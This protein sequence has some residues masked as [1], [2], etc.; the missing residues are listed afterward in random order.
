MVIFKPSLN[1][2]IGSFS[3][4]SPFLYSISISL[5][6]T[7]Y[8]NLLEEK[9]KQ[10]NNVINKQNEEK[11]KLWAWSDMT[12]LD[13]INEKT[14]LN[15]VKKEIAKE[16]VPRKNYVGTLYAQSDD[17]E[18]IL[19][20]SENVFRIKVGEKCGEGEWHEE[21][22]CEILE[23]YKGTAD[24]TKQYRIDLLCDHVSEGEEYIVAL[25]KCFNRH[26]IDGDIHPCYDITSKN[27]IISVE[28]E[29]EVRN[30]LVN[31]E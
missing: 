31:G 29:E 23:Q 1:K 6:F 22:S 27:S 5:L 11:N 3:T 4:D 8:S 30:I 15:Y 14:F 13:V 24:L 28:K 9:I 12:L 10:I 16:P 2:R 26:G 7:L 18:T 20:S 17:L 19:Q 25:T 21:Y